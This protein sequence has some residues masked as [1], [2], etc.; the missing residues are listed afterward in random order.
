MCQHEVEGKEESITS[1]RCFHM[2]NSI[3]S[4]AISEM[5]ETEDGRG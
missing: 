1:P 2:S 4:D 5:Q 3:D